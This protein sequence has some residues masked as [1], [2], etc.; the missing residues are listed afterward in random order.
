MINDKP[1]YHLRQSYL[2]T[3]RTTAMPKAIN[4][5]KALPGVVEIR[6]IVD[7]LKGIYHGLPQLIE[8]VLFP[9]SPEELSEKAPFFFKPLSIVSELNWAYAYMQTYWKE[10]EWFADIKNE[11]ENRFMLGE[12]EQC[13][14]LLSEVHN[15][16][17]VS[18]WY[19]EVKCLLFEY[20]GSQSQKLDFISNVLKECKNNTNYIPSLIYNLYERTSRRLSP[21]KFDE[22]L[23]ALYKKNKTDLHEDFYKYILYR[24]NYYN[25]YDKVEL[26]IP[27]MFESLSSLIDRYLIIVSIIKSG[28]A[29][30]MEDSTL[31][32][33][34]YY[35][36]KKTHD[37][38]LYPVIALKGYALP[39]DYYNAAF[40]KMIDCYYIGDYSS[41]ME[42]AACVI[43]QCPTLFDAY[44]FYCRA[45]IYQGF[46]YS[47][48]N[49]IDM[50][51]PANEICK[52]VYDVLSY[53]EVNDNL[54]SLYQINK[55][56]YSFQ[57]A[58]SL[59][60]F[61]KKEWNEYINEN[62]KY[63]YISNF[64][65]LC[66]QMWDNEEDSLNYIRTYSQNQEYSL[67]CSVWEKRIQH[68]YVE[69][70]KLTN[71]IKEPIN[72][73]YFFHKELYTTA[74]DHCETLYKSATN[75][76]PIRQIAVSL[77]IKCLFQQNAIQ[78]AINKYVDYYISDNP[79][80]AKV[81]TKTIIK[82]L[83]ENLYEGIR[84]SINLVI[85]VALTCK[86]TVD[87][88]FILFEFCELKG[89]RV[90]SEL[91]KRLDVKEYGIEKIELF[92][93]LMNDDETL[94]HYLNIDSFKERLAERKKILQYIISLNTANKDA[95]QNM[96][97]KVD[98]ALL[99][100]N[101]SRKIDESKI[102][103][104]DEAIINYKLAEIDGLFSR[105]ILLFETLVSQ[106]RH[107][108]VVDFN[109]SSFF[110]NQDAYER[111]ANTKTTINGNGLFEV[112]NSLYVDV[113]EQFLNSDYGLVAYLSTRVRHGE[114][115]TMLR[116]E[117]V[118]RN[119]ILSMRN[120]KY[121]A[122]TFWTQTYNLESREQSIVNSALIEFSQTFD[123]AVMFLIKQ[124]LQIYDKDHKPEGLFNYEV[125]KNEIAYKAVEI[126]LLLKSGNNDRIH[127]C[128]LMLK[129]LWEKT[130]E[131]LKQ[132]RAYIDSVFMNVISK[133]I[134]TLEATIRDDMP[135]GYAKTELLAQ[136]RS[137][138]EAM[139]MKIQKLSKWF[140]VSQPK[141]EDVDFKA[142]SHQ[143]Y[144][145]VRLSHI[146]CRTDDQ[147]V[148]KGTSFKIKSIYV[149]HYADIL[150]NIIYNMF[151]HGVDMPN[152]KRHFELNIC[153]L[154]DEVLIDFVNDTDGKPEELNAIFAEKI[155]G[156]TSIFG[157]G[158]SGIAKVNKIL[159]RDLNN[160]SNS[161]S[162]KVENGKCYTTVVI[163][164]NSFK[165]I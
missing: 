56:L 97:K 20:R 37:K 46:E 147:L 71:H 47:S 27:I 117:M 61:V 110:E 127:F 120:N 21:Y 11:F 115:E 25:Q 49:R 107:I 122:D 148:I 129:W 84:R 43:K 134:S 112:F 9:K 102:Y 106:R 100:Y 80:V 24:L 94:R 144:N 121:Q 36:Y 128:Q 155:N 76:I 123:N 142:V 113:R 69:E 7:S 17:G 85:F 114:L 68:E 82:Y 108:F 58:A 23:N 66:S 51:S 13:E 50:H 156:D 157:E 133:A 93:T 88:S 143:V 62:I 1:S 164:L 64:D 30:N 44:V 78:Q 153:I 53:K 158:G 42:L 10:L 138:R 79:S 35:L 116:P 159:K 28:L 151:E 73:D 86:E 105:Y 161:I 130:E 111:V 55:N 57:I 90:P 131:S 89:V 38:A 15:R 109:N 4:S 135:E 41:T 63:L 154:N 32:S 5:L 91:I 54:Y 52:K 126:G 92:F 152:G 16:L 95:Y 140:T 48:P 101:L 165:A 137:A 26:S 70:T 160:P 149:I 8:G 98:D 65:P 162:M 146:N 136:I 3:F 72:I 39:N 14:E 2:R 75:C 103:A 18:L 125:N 104:N 83:Q 139:T 99:V 59:D 119:L 34:A 29:T 118:Q 132:I 124:K 163:K 60:F 33:K 12:F 81:D 145:S 40:I 6:E 96:L 31:M 19:Y 141:I 67:A 150:R 74:Y 87:K 22:D 45:L 77:M